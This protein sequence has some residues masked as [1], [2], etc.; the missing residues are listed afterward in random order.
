MIAILSDIHSDLESLIAAFDA[1]DKENITDIYCTG[2]LVE[3][4][5]AANELICLLQQ[6]KVKCVM[7][8]N[9][10]SYLEQLS[11]SDCDPEKD[12]LSEF[13]VEELTS[14]SFDFLDQLPAYLSEE[15]IYLV[16]ALPPD[17]FLKYIDYQSEP[18]LIKAFESFSQSIA[19]V[20]HT[21][22]YKIYELTDSGEIRKHSF[23][24]KLFDLN[25][26]SR[27]IINAGSLGRP[28]DLENEAG[29]VLY[30]PDNK[31]IIRKCLRTDNSICLSL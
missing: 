6:N 14:E 28:R 9:D 8:N 2:D 21:H 19:F 24:D 3:F 26:Y 10:D 1:L 25:Q 20:G 18:A 12:G 11:Y 29:F 27:Y 31:Q 30:D 15:G 4:P 16:H 13:P 22:E 23:T 17:S 7:G 5:E